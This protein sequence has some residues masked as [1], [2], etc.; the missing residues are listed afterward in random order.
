MTDIHAQQ[1]G[2]ALPDFSAQLTGDFAKRVSLSQGAACIGG[3][4]G[5]KALGKEFACAASVETAEAA[6]L[7]DP[8]D[9]LSTAG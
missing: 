2:N 4:P 8:P 9:A 5:G 7:H 1:P 6:H 3:S